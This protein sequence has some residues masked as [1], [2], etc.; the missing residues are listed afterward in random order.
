MAKHENCNLKRI[1]T[2]NFLLK[3]SVKLKIKGEKIVEKGL[4][5]NF[6]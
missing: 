5:Y 4:N 6:S 3:E 2:L 1:L